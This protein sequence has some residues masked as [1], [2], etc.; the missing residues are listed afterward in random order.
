M[1]GLYFLHLIFYHNTLNIKNLWI[2]PMLQSYTSN[3]FFIFFLGRF[4]L[5]MSCLHLF[6]FFLDWV[7]YIKERWL[8]KSFWNALIWNDH[9]IFRCWWNKIWDTSL[10]FII[11]A[12]IAIIVIYII[13][14]ACNIFNEDFRM[15]NSVW[16]FFLYPWTDPLSHFSFLLLEWIDPKTQ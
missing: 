5:F 10:H 7:I 13:H 8:I 12:W 2:I 11:G 4:I 3:R 16:F 9:L 1:K 14:V 15:S 6:N